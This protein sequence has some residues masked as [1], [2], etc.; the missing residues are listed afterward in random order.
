MQPTSGPSALSYIPEMVWNDT[1]ASVALGHGI[2]AGGGGASTIFP[3]PTWQIGTVP[4]STHVPDISLNASNFHDPYLIC[5]QAFFTSNNSTATSCTSGFRASDNSLAAAGGTSVGAPTF[6]GILA[7]IN[8]ATR[9]AKPSGQGNVNP[10]P[11][12]PGQDHANRFPRHHHRQQQCALHRGHTQLPFRVRYPVNFPATTPASATIRPAAWARSM[13][14]SWSEPGPI[15]RALPTLRWA[16]P[17]SIS[18]LRDSPV[19]RP[20]P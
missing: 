12:Q 13:P 10:K 14:T 3:K 11:L 9:A 7:I 20:L 19:L 2:D 16:V 5:S 4:A 8:Q 1:A 17:Q 18:R 15:S 6:A